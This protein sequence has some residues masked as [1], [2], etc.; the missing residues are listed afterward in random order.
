M[1]GLIHAEVSEIA[2]RWFKEQPQYEGWVMIPN[3]SG[4]ADYNGI[5]VP[6]G[7][8]P[9]GGGSDFILFGSQIIHG[10]RLF[11]CEFLE[12]KTIAYP[13]IS[14]KQRRWLS[15][16]SGFGALCWI[17]REIPEPPGYLVEGWS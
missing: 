3:R 9:N 1:L 17:F 16:M 11:T 4:R 6:Y 13:T 12:V 5:H 15:K 10:K 2:I 14:I 7:I 8:P